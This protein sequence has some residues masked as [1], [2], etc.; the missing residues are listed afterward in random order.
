MNQKISARD[1]EWNRKYNFTNENSI[2]I[3]M[4][5]RLDQAF[6]VWLFPDKEP[7]FYKCEQEV[8]MK[9]FSIQ[10]EQIEFEMDPFETP[11][12]CRYPIEI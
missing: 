4:D 10:N 2:G 8:F 12:F 5:I 3:L 1:N 7:R 11:H 9:N 6:W